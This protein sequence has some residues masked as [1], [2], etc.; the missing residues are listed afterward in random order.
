MNSI[1]EPF[2][3][4]LNRAYLIRL[5][6]SSALLICASL[7]HADEKLSLVNWSSDEG[8]QRFSQSKSKAD[9][10]ILANHFESQSNKIF[11]GVASSTIVLNALR[12]RNGKLFQSMPEANSVLTKS[13]REYLPIVVN[14]FF[15]RYTQNNIFKDGAKTKVEVLGK[16][17]KVDG[18]E[19]RDIGLQLEQLKALLESNDLKVSKTV[20]TKDSSIDSIRTQFR[21]NLAKKSDFIL[22]NYS[23]KALDQK[24]G[25]HISPIG[26][27]DAVSDSVLILDVNSNKADWVWA[28]LSLLVSAMAS[29]DTVENRG[30]LVV[31]EK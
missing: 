25:G 20:V 21:K 15:N 27:Y 6:V 16:P 9:F 10:F 14:P 24:G 19:K 12:V 28:P 23:R 1:L 31:S 13:D 5:M 3:T 2:R 17:I 29:F 4:I 26:A 8:I 18:K 7:I 11:C 22:V 30:Y